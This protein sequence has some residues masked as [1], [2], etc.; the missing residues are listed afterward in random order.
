[1]RTYLGIDLGTSSVKSLLMDED[2]KM[3]GSAQKE[4]D[5]IKPEQTW[6]EQDMHVL[7]KAV[8]ETLQKL[9]SE[10]TD[11]IKNLDGIVIQDRCTDLF[12]WIKMES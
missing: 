7:W 11:Q 4:Y 6:A 2:G 10:C 8:Q 1:M 3:I 5:I 12:P 9:S